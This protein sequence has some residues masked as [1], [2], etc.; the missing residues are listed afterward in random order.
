MFKRW[1]HCT[2]AYC[3]VLQREEYDNLA[4]EKRAA[5]V[6]KAELEAKVLL[7]IGL[8]LK[9]HV[10]CINIDYSYIKK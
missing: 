1:L 9:K 7:V 10:R 8:Y 2:S 4:A 6:S 3:G 5:V